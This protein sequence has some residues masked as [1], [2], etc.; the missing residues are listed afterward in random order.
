MGVI[1]L[2]C[3]IKMRLLYA[4]KSKATAL[5]ESAKEKSTCML[6]NSHEMACAGLKIAIAQC[7]KLLGKEKT[8][9]VISK[10]QVITSKIEER[11]PSSWKD[12]LA[13]M[14]KAKG[15]SK[16]EETAKTKKLK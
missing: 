2:A 4:V 3:T 12:S 11:I 7:E 10:T 1:G 8:K 16:T 15:A 14:L 5:L 13:K 6:Q 9:V